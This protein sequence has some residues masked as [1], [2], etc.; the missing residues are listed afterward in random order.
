M[1][2]VGVIILYTNGNIDPKPKICP[3]RLQIEDNIGEGIHIHW[4][5]LRLDF[6][7]HDFL[8]LAKACE[9]ARKNISTS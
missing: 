9:N 3:R 6:S 5:N 7:I 1:L 2:N 8:T 4:R